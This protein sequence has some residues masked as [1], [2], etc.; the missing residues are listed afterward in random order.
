MPSGDKFR[1][2]APE[3]CRNCGTPLAGAYCSSCG[4][5]ADSAIPS[6]P[7][8]LAE[9]VDSLY[10]LDSRIWRTLAR[11]TLRPGRLTT[12]YLAG[13]R[14]LYVAPFRLYLILSLIFF[15]LDSIVADEGD[16]GVLGDA[17][18]IV[19]TDGAPRAEDS[20][21]AGVVETC[22]AEL[23]FLPADGAL[24]RRALAICMRVTNDPR[25]LLLA[26]ADRVPAMTFLLIPLVAAFLK[27]LYARSRRGYVA[28][29][30]YVFHVHAFC[31][32]AATISLI[33]ARLSSIP[34]FSTA[35]TLLL[36]GLWMY[37]AY[38]VY[39]AQHVVYGQG[40]VATALKCFL[41]L[42]AYLIALALTIGGGLVYSALTL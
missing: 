4:Q 13:K 30:I 1:S 7:A 36:T 26:F 16:I 17:P 18:D 14:A 22:R 5:S 9:F 20:A 8:L 12:D 37:V 33:A 39:R 11:L 29:L 34:L 21:A 19:E 40:R 41:L 25:A 35:I 38:Y 32:V 2:S 6:L 10:N 15:L 28:H 42:N 31:F 27:A 24:H 23:T 3:A